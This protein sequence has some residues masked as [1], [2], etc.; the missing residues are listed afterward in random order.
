MVGKGHMPLNLGGDSMCWHLQCPQYSSQLYMATLLWPH[1][2]QNLIKK[3]LNQD[4]ILSKVC[5][6]LTVEVIPNVRAAWMVAKDE[7]LKQD[8]IS[9]DPCI[10]SLPFTHHPKNPKKS[11]A[12]KKDLHLRNLKKK[13]CLRISDF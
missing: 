1:S 10:R 11:N 7:E 12:F 2:Q 4:L 13:T 9:I 6:E 5:R 8:L 3:E